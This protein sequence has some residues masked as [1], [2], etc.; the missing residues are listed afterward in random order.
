[1]KKVWMKGVFAVLLGIV[2]LAGCG[3]AAKEDSAVSNNAAQKDDGH[4]H[5]P[6]E[7]H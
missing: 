5:K 2:V 6:G 4:N 7:T 1:M 3:G